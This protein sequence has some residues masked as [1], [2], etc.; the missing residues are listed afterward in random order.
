MKQVEEWLWP[1]LV[2]YAWLFLG[3]GMLYAAG[4]IP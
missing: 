3:I 4:V 2:L 1:D